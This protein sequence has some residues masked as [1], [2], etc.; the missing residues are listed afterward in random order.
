MLYALGRVGGS[1]AT[2]RLGSLATM[3]EA[4]VGVGSRWAP[5]LRA[6]DGNRPPDPRVM[7]THVNQPLFINRGVSPT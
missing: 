5:K 7:L 2:R 1:L 4:G 6:P 3:V